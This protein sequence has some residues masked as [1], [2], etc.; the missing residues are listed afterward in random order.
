MDKQFW[1]NKWEIQDI[2]FNQQATNPYLIQFFSR[3]NL[4]KGQ[5]ILVP[6]CGKSIDMLWLKAQ[7]FEV[8]GCE[9]SVLACEQFF[10]ENNLS[11]QPEQKG[12][13]QYFKGEQITLIAGD[14]FALDVNSFSQFDAIYDRAAIVALPEKMRE[15]YADKIQQFSVKEMLMVTA[16][17][18]QAEMQGPP[19][20]VDEIEIKKHFEGMYQIETLYHQKAPSLAPH[21]LAKGLTAAEE[22]VFHL[23]QK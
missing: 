14:F 22:W 20:S 11:Y 3:L 8:I 10:K 17:Y 9:L 4:S 7:G 23:S 19:F 15:L 16:S 13:Y 18:N 5:T 1:Q 21:L 12:E 2:A 6:L